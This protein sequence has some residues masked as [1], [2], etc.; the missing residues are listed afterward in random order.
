MKK[1]LILT[2]TVV[3]VLLL[4][5]GAGIIFAFSGIGNGVL[6][7]YIQERLQEETALPVKVDRFSLDAKQ[8][9]LLCSLNTQLSIEIVTNYDMWTRSFKGIYRAKVKDFVFEKQHLRQADI[10]GKFEGNIEKFDVDGAGTALDAKL[11]Y[12]LVVVKDV[13]K[14]I[15]ATM[16][17]IQLSELLRLAGEDAI[18]TGVVDVDI[19]MPDIGEESAKGDGY[20][21]LSNGVFNRK[22]ITQKYGYTLPK[23]SYVNAKVNVQLQGKI[24]HF[25]A[26]AKSNLFHLKT[27]EGFVN[28][29]TQNL[30][31]LY[32]VDVKDLRILTQ[33]KLAGPMQI[34][35]AL[36]VKEKQV[37][38]KGESH[39]LGGKLH[40]EVSDKIALTLQN[41][42][43]EKLLVLLK[44][45]RY[46]K[47]LL[48]MTA[49]IEKEMDV[50]TYEVDVKKALLNTQ[51]IAKVTGYTLPKSSYVTL[52]AQGKI[53]KGVLKSKVILK[54]TLGRVLLSDILYKMKENTLTSK[55]EVNIKDIGML[56]P[57][58]KR[59]KTAPL[60][61]KG[62]VVFDKTLRLDG[63]VMGVAKKL[64]FH[65]DSKQAKL[66][67]QALSL[68]KIWALSALPSYLNGNVNAKV[69]VLDMKKLNGH[70]TIRADQLVA[71]PK[72]MKKLL[73]KALKLRIK[74]KS[75]GSLKEAKVYAHTTIQSN[76]A[77]MVLNNTLFDIK[78][79]VLKSAYSIDIP[80]MMKLYPLTDKELY[81]KM[82]LE[83][84]LM[85]DDTLSIWGNTASLGGKINYTFKGDVFKG[86]LKAVPI[87]GIMRMLGMTQVISGTANGKIMQNIK[88]Q[89]GFA[90][91]TIAGF[92]V[93]PSKTTNTIKMLIGKDPARIIFKSTKLHA[94][95]QG[96]ITTYT[97]HAKG[98]SASLDITKGRL[99]KKTN[100]NSAYF[101]FVYEKYIINGKIHGATDHPKIEI[102]PT[103]MI[104][105]KVTKEIGKSLDKV[106]KGQMGN[107]LQGLKF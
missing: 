74:L 35:G 45:P 106:L 51:H 91:I 5:V 93:K 52:N 54:S 62:A 48:D 68:E 82:H 17:G 71:N 99:S 67:A 44:Q 76:M 104:K 55:Y 8:I 19:D 61:A 57:A 24:L 30:H 4:F 95:M 26:L 69:D 94:N 28:L 97:L 46:A 14:K 77:D 72:E 73:G 37:S 96:D 20:I 87:S 103:S 107:L 89:K 58:K 78:T 38:V 16:H 50:G 98:T 42:V 6:K 88:T 29:A 80:D 12:H 66:D 25:F 9:K 23:K 7:S 34:E 81:G 10:K 83:G 49:N 53:K 56:M 84:N 13:P 63:V 65:Y 39:S 79:Q 92:Q 21:T 18:A 40:F 11:N 60:H 47:G 59:G 75:K 3:L 22:M 70:F 86:T 105:N 41:I 101:K 1:I 27:K 36:T 100:T 33:N 64:S 90:D 43:I 31:T 102:D 15:K 2:S 32:N 85:Q